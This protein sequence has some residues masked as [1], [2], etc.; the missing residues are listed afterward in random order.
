LE[1]NA[2]HGVFDGEGTKLQGSMFGSA[3]GG[4]RAPLAGA[5]GDVHVEVPVTLAE[6]YNGCVKVA[7]Y[8]RQVVALDGHTAKTEEC[9]KTL[10]V[11]PGQAAGTTLRFKG[12]GNQQLK[13]ESTDLIVTLVEASVPDQKATRRGND[14]IFSCQVSLQQALRAEPAELVTLDGRLLKV[15]V[16][17]VVTPKTLI[18]IEGEGMPIPPV[19]GADPLEPLRKG[20]LYVRFEIK[21]PKKLSDDQRQRLQSV[22]AA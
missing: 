20:D 1:C 5:V 3:F 7:V 2:F 8:S 9:L 19:K 11:K 13:R 18:K 6:F 22:L 12:D 21:F 17:E 4:A 14:L 10:V 15:P 16:D